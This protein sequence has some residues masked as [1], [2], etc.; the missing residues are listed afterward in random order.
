MSRNKKIIIV[1]EMHGSINS[2]L[3]SLG[4]EVTNLPLI[5]RKQILEVVGDYIGIVIRSKT[6]LDNELLSAAHQL[7]FIARAGAGIDKIDEKYCVKKGIEILN[8]P[9]G[10]R[11]ALG[12]HLTGMLLTLFNRIHIADREI[13]KGNWNRKGNRGYELNG[14]TVGIIGYGNMGNAFA[15]RLSGFNC[16]VLAYDKYKEGF[17]DSLVKEATMKE[18]FTET[19]ILSLH[20]PLTEETDRF[21]N[22]RFFKKFKKS[23][24]LL[25]TARGKILPLKDLLDMM[26]EKKIMGAA[27]DVLEN[28]NP[29]SYDENE[30]ALF[31]DLVSRDNVILTPHV[32][33]WSQESYVKINEVLVKKII[34][35]NLI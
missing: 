31:E 28:E 22:K 14:R 29:G 8:S 6:E 13:R 18:I 2:D 26:N 5:S 15:Q 32:A 19:D 12:E 4:F 10:N 21:Y 3:E 11:D 27:L 9:E 17:T 25:N 24:F 16:R 33:G 1:D 35:L 20:V 7:K 30:K 34:G 23:I